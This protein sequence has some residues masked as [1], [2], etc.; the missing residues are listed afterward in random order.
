MLFCG[1]VKHW[2]SCSSDFIVIMREFSQYVQVVSPGHIPAQYIP[3]L[4][5]PSFF[6]LPACVEGIDFE[7][8]HFCNFRTSVTLD[9]V[10]G[11]TAVH[12]S[13]STNYVPSFI[14][15]S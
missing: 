14:K 1:V 3:F 6:F 9:P 4:S 5:L 15:I 13:S 7:I 8:S 2:C 10:Q 11:H 12:H